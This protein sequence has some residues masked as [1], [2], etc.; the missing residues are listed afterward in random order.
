MKKQIIIEDIIQSLIDYYEYGN[1]SPHIVFTGAIHGDEVSGVRICQ[2]LVEYLEETPPKKGS[3]TVIPVCNP[4][5]FRQMRRC[6]FFDDMDL[7]RVFPGKEDG[8]HSERIADAIWKLTQNAEVII[9]LHNCGFYAKS[10]SLAIYDENPHTRNLAEL[11]A[12]PLLVQ[13]AGTPGQLFTESCR[14]RGQKALI[15]EMPNGAR[16]GV[17]NK[18]STELGWESIMNV[19]RHEGIVAEKYIRH[20]VEAF[21]KI[22]DITVSENGFWTPAKKSGDSLSKGDLLGA[23]NSR[24][25]YAEMDFFALAVNDASYVFSG[26]AI[27]SYVIKNK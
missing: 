6:N 24:E 26:D 12:I 1:G 21:G 16:P 19:L 27:T 4:A 5:A 14:R 25:I 22:E 2:R 8:S 10:Y 13:S 3:V 9:D 11:F 7:N 15:I 20:N 17:V 18:E 23:I